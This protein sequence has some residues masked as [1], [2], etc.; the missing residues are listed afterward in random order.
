MKPRLAPVM[1][2]TE[3]PVRLLGMRISARGEKLF[4]SELNPCEPEADSLFSRRLV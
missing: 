2:G 4:L 1:S 3:W